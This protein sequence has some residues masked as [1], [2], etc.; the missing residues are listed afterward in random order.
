MRNVVILGSTGSIGSQA[1]EVIRENRDKFNI[2]GIAIGGANPK[3]AIEQAQEFGLSADQIAVRNIEGAKEVSRALGGYVI[4]GENSAAALVESQEADVVLNALVGASGLPATM[5]A[6]RSDATLALANKESLVAGGRIVLDAAKPGQI[7]PVDSEHS[8]MAQCMRGTRRSEIARLVLTASGGPFRGWEREGLMEVTTEEAVVHPT[9]SMGT[10]NTIN[11]S[12]LVN[13]GLELIEAAMLFDMDPDKIDVTIHPQSVIHSLV[14]F[15]DGATLAQASP[16]SMKL[17]IAHALDWPNRVPDVQE[18]LDFSQAFSWEF[19]PLDNEVFPAVCLAREVAKKGDPYPAIYN[20]A[21]EAAVEAFFAGRIKFPEI[22]DI[23][24]EVLDEADE[25]AAVPSDVFDV[26]RVESRTRE[27][28]A[29]AIA[30]I[31]R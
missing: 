7:V 30:R 23:I 26:M 4:T 10:M 9:W 13:K 12:T 2:V 19:E 8:A 16:P 18:P 25:F 21:N 1:V 20:A 17:P 31:E 24:G 29:A 3:A 6:L 27:R 28:V 22:V 5:A 15:T 14:T 11:S